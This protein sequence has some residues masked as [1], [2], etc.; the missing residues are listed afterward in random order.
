MDHIINEGG[1]R[2]TCCN[3]P[4]KQHTKVVWPLLDAITQPHLFEIA[5][6]RGFSEKE[7]RPTE[8]EREG[9]MQGDMKKYQLT[10]D[11]AQHRKYWMTKI[12]AGPL[13]GDGQQR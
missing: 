9:N 13:Q 8:K 10:E 3:F 5:K 11:M 2:K 4:R 7:Q 1:A 6:T 12:L